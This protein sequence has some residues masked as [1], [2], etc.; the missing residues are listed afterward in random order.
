MLISHFS[1]PLKTLFRFLAPGLFV[2]ILTAASSTEIPVFKPENIETHLRYLADDALEGRMTGTKGYDLAAAYVAEQFAAMGLVPAGDDGGYLQEVPLQ[3]TSPLPG[4]SWLVMTTPQGQLTFPSGEDVIVWPSDFE[5]EI[6]REAEVVFAG[7]GIEAPEIDHNDYQYLDVRG[8]IIAVFSGAPKGFSAEDQTRYGTAAKQRTALKKGAVAM[9]FLRTPA[10]EEQFSFADL[11]VYAATP[12]MTWVGKDG[13]PKP[14]PDEIDLVVSIGATAAEALFAGAP[15]NFA[16]ILVES[17]SKTSPPKGFPLDVTVSIRNSSKH[18]MISSANIAGML[19]GSDPE[20]GREYV[21]IT[22]H[23]DH[24]GIGEPI[25]GD[26]IYNGAID[27]ASGVSIMLE[28]ARAFAESGIRPKRSLLFLA[29]TAEE[30]G[31]LGADYFAHFPTV[32]IT[33]IVANINMDATFMFHNFVDVIVLGAEHSTLGLTTEKVAAAMD[34]VLTPDPMP[35]FNLFRRSDHYALVEKGIPA[36]VLLPGFLETAEG[37]NGEEIFLYY[38]QNIY[39]TPK[40]DLD[41]DFDFAVGAK[42]AKLNWRLINEIANSP[43]RP[44]WY[45]G[46]FYGDLFA[47]DAE[48]S[49]RPVSAGTN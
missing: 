28:I 27:N 2:A 14:N 6:V 45:Q 4:Q 44:Q 24:M 8:K 3:K 32:P 15:R 39:H 40:D 21:V 10:G 35:Q 34:I 38:M 47:P 16:T 11:K 46:D 42:F 18:E 20:L 23:L 30:E 1:K 48:K 7:F 33:D 36:V 49:P 22:S 17:E 25:D 37:D 41:Q 31:L 12:S 13:K 5:T 9:L 19:A 26:A 29:V 43:Q